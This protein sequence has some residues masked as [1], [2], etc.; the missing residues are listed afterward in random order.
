MSADPKSTKMTYDLTA[1]LAFWDLQTQKLLVKCWWN[2]QWYL[3]SEFFGTDDQNDDAYATVG[4]FMT[5]VYLLIIVIVLLNLLIAMMNATV[6][7]L[8]EKYFEICMCRRQYQKSG[9]TGNA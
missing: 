3:L 9:V 7:V 8:V 5:V 4:Y 2:S 6:Q 1:F